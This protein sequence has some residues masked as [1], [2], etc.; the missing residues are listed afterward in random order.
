M[1][2]ADKQLA[3]STSTCQEQNQGPFDSL[4]CFEVVSRSNKRRRRP[5][6]PNMCYDSAGSYEVITNPP[7]KRPRMFER[8]WTNSMPDHGFDEPDLD[9]STFHEQLNDSNFQDASFANPFA[10]SS[11]EQHKLHNSL[12]QDFFDNSEFS[13]SEERN[14]QQS[15]QIDASENGIVLRFKTVMERQVAIAMEPAN[16]PQDQLPGNVEE[17]LAGFRKNNQ[18][19]DSPKN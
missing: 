10:H 3:V 9:D 13:I 16:P 4:G 15:Q 18:L 14:F 6:T 5:Q 12:P 8:E 17:Y 19:N 11:F 2:D 1:T 7:P